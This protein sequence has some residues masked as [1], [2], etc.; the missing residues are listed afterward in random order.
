[1][2]EPDRFWADK[3]SISRETAY[4]LLQD[5]AKLQNQVR[6]KLMKRG[7][8]GYI[9]PTQATFPTIEQFHELI[10]GCG[11]IPTYAW[12]DGTSKGEQDI[13]EL[14]SLMVSKGV[15]AVNIVPDRNWNIPDTGL[16]TVKLNN[17][18][19]FINLAI[20]LDLPINVGTEMNSFGNKLVD[21]FDTPELSGYHQFFLSGAYFVYG[22]TMMERACKLGYQSDWA[23]SY[24][25]GRKER[26][27]FFEKIGRKLDPGKGIDQLSKF[28]E[29]FNPD[30][31]LGRLT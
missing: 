28:S 4:Q 15:G 13:I 19:Q 11:A 1:V 30:D 25:P 17:L 24:F 23:R 12:L 6:T 5:Y 14:L 16:K 29:I 27:K 3:L 7:G 10:I 26:N 31:V 21:E 8:P 2:N 22:H 9:E 18:N 20:D